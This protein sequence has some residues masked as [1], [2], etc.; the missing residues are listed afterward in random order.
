MSGERPRAA[1][2]AIAGKGRGVRALQG[3]AAGAVIEAA[4]TILLSSQDCELIERT[5][6]GDYYFAHP[7]NEEEGLVILGLASL[8]NH[9]ER[10]NA[11]LRWR[12]QEQIGWIAELVALRPIAQGE[13]VTRR[14]RCQPWFRVVA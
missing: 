7:E 5:P 1:P 10:P 3:I 6:V 11:E 4:P 13:E 2:A 14:Y 9:A 8:A 12:C